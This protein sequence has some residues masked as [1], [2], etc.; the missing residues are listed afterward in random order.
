[1]SL[2][3]LILALI[4]HTP[5]TGYDLDTNYR[6]LIQY[7]W[8]AKQRQIYNVL[9]QLHER[10]WVQ[11]EEVAQIDAADK[12]VYHITPT[13]HDALLDW[14]QKPLPRQPV[15]LDWLGQLYFSTLIKPEETIQLLAHRRQLL[16]ERVNELH[17]IV[18]IYRRL[19]N[20]P[21]NERPT[22]LNVIFRQLLT[23]H[24]GLVTLDQNIHWLTETID[25]LKRHQTTDKSEVASDAHALLDGMEQI[26]ARHGDEA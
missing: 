12:K 9:K 14:L 18:N 16:V 6:S 26:L 23:V 21:P 15:R 20:A 22:S 3:H 25:M 11:V 4:Y 24:Y 17:N 1:M 10:G 13:G 8:G 7:F 5:R 2:K 19:V